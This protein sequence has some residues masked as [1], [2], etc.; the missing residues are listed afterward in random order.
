MNTRI[1]EN[2]KYVFM[3]H[4]LHNLELL[5]LKPDKSIQKANVK[6]RFKLFSKM[7]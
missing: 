2:H 4:D 7:M 5:R 3:H 6:C 1:L